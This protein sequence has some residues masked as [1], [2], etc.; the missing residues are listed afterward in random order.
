MNPD[1]QQMLR[2]RLESQATKHHYLPDPKTELVYVLDGKAYQIYDDRVIE[3]GDWHY[4][5]F[6]RNTLSPVDFLLD[7]AAAQ[8]P[9]GYEIEIRM[10]KG[11]GA[12]ELTGP[13]GEVIELPYSESGLED[14]FFTALFA[15]Q[16][17][18]E[19]QPPS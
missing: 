15:A 1:R 2:D 9:E 10:G 16:R 14:D 4:Y 7:I 17:L 6:R 8:L 13:D 18:A 3:H 5:R 19:S 11:E 12:V